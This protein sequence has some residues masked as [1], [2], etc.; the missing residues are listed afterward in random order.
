M[1]L[2]SFPKAENK[3]AQRL[4]PSDLRGFS[5][6][7]GEMIGGRHSSG[8]ARLLEPVVFVQ[9]FFD[10]IRGNCNSHPPSA[11]RSLLE[12][13]NAPVFRLM[14]HPLCEGLTPDPSCQEPKSEEYWPVMKKKT[15]GEHYAPHSHS[16]DT[17]A[18]IVRWPVSVHQRT[19]DEHA[20][21]DSLEARAELHIPQNHPLINGDHS[22]NSFHGNTHCDTRLNP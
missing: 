2:H 6:R 9:R 15:G 22:P 21:T 7:S 14:S 18:R 3:G 20:M 13:L 10:N 11:R 4:N 17:L 12:I 5:R 8:W 16:R 19:V 1:T